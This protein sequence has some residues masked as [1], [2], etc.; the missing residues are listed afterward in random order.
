[1]P[2]S[3]TTRRH[4]PTALLRAL[5]GL[6]GLAALLSGIPLALLRFGTLPST[7][8]GP[9]RILEA[10]TAP[11]DGSLLMTALTLA[12]W[13]V[14]T[15]LT[16]PLLVEIAAVI[17]RHSTPRIPGLG[18][19]QRI[20]GFLI[21]SILLASPAA[22]AAA[23]TPA[24][25]ATATAPHHGTATG[26][27]TPTSTTTDKADT[28]DW[29]TYRVTTDDVALWDLAEKLFGEGGGPR[30]KDIA[31]LNPG[32]DTKAD[33]KEGTVLNVP[34]DA[35]IPAQHEKQATSTSTDNDAHNDTTHKRVEHATVTVEPG[36]SLSHIADDELDDPTAWP[37]IYK[38]N[39]DTIDD[40][41]LIYPGQ[42]LK[43]P[44]AAP[45]EHHT[46]NTTD[47]TPDHTD[48]KPTTSTPSSPAPTHT[49]ETNDPS[50]SPTPAPSATTSR[51]PHQPD[52]PTPKTSHT[53][54]QDGQ[55]GNLFA[56]STAIA[57]AGAGILA[58]STIGFITTRRI[59][60]QRRRRPGRRIPLP[61]ARAATTEQTLRTVQNPTGTAF[62]DAALRTL[63]TNLANAEREL[64]EIEAAIL[65]PD[66]IDLH[67]AEPT[68]ACE[69]FTAH[70]T[71]PTV[72]QCRANTPALLPDDQLAD[73]DPP[74]PG[75]VSIGWDDDSGLVLIDLEAIGTLHLIGNPE[76]CRAVLRALAVELATSILV[77]HL[78]VTAVGTAAERL[79]T[80]V[81]ERVARIQRL[82]QAVTSLAAHDDD[83]RRALHTAGAPS[84]RAARLMPTADGAWTPRILLCCDDTADDEEL[85]ALAEALNERP[86]TSSAV[87]TTIDG[88]LHTATGWTLNTA[89]ADTPVTLPGPGITVTLQTLSDT[90]YTDILS[91]LTT[92]GSEADAPAPAWTQHPSLAAELELPRS[93]DETPADEAPAPERRSG[94]TLSDVLDVPDEE[95]VDH[96]GT[97]DEATPASFA[98]HPAPANQEPAAASPRTTVH[99][100]G[101]PGP[102][103]PP[104]LAHAEPGPTI[105]VLG[106]V[107]IQHAA[108]RVDT[109]R[110]RSCTELAAYL[111]LHP[112]VDHNAID[113]ALWP[114]RRVTKSTRAPL[115]S[116]LRSWLG[117]S[118]DGTPHFPRVTE[119]ANH[120]YTLGPHVTSDWTQFQDL[121]RAGMHNSGEDADLALRRALA[122]VR[123]RPFAGVD[124]RRYTWAEPWVQEMTSAIIDTAHEL[125]TRRLDAHDPRSALWA[126]SKG[127]TA[128]EENEVL[129]RD[130]FIAHHAAG[131]MEALRLAAARLER[132]NEELDVDMD[133]ETATLLRSLLPR[134]AAVT[135]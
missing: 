44:T 90:D 126:A 73:T 88:V 92:A 103:A 23:A 10:L 59:L 27:P 32:L 109:N 129:H 81:P 65:R 91:I 36:D 11:D 128:A 7:M 52:A 64:P 28:Q 33:L 19:P 15:W 18:T 97:S 38:I 85:S 34:A 50:H 43:L 117:D 111:T 98:E 101:T 93:E 123:G 70:S 29:P 42:H 25:A 124:P 22:A 39:R 74:Y 76:R 12:G 56:P 21:G 26:E 87:I 107:D 89:D 31:A 8:P 132:I 37:K 14:W 62:L 72:W 116:R 121:Y 102:T 84:L 108:G 58:A 99:L 20:A 48:D 2:A 96:E 118:P 78:E 60:Q 46:P 125:A 110:Q 71:Q 134:A 61:Q 4:W 3:P 51:T 80:A 114:D 41:N 68:P 115:I 133:T 127:L 63:A 66:G 131:D 54:A 49:P 5:A 57:L 13:A 113:Q 86:R 135:R 40:P 6:A 35:R 75:L 24:A 95:D 30:W 82:D 69:P 130:V 105:R 119:D 77:P 104:T 106:P 120:R 55:T 94:P 53:P 16:L 122:L 45:S 100:D 17:V 9:G 1:M 67:L 47:K 79:E 83:Q 112:G